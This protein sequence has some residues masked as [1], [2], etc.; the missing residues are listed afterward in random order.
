M[1]NFKLVKMPIALHEKSELCQYYLHCD[2]DLKILRRFEY[3][4][5]RFYQQKFIF[6]FVAISFFSIDILMSVEQKEDTETVTVTYWN[7]RGRCEPIRMLLAASGVKFTNV[8]FENP[9]QWN[10]LQKS[11]KLEYGQVPLVEMDGLNLV[12]SSAI[13]YYIARKYDL[14]PTGKSIED[15]KKAYTV[16]QVFEAT[17]DCRGSLAGFPFT[18]NVSQIFNEYEKKLK[19]RYLKKW[20]ELILQN[21]E[22]SGF[23]VG[24]TATMADVCI[25]EILDYLQAV[26]GE[27]QYLQIVKNLN[28]VQAL[29]EKILSLGWMKEYIKKRNS[30]K[31]SWEAYAKSVQRV[32][33]DSFFEIVYLIRSIRISYQIKKTFQISLIIFIL[34]DETELLEEQE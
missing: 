7:G 8:F 14:Y 18:L 12:Q 3:T 26:V 32:A 15:V 21:P 24:K 11:G 27:E 29:P 33:F 19:P 28:A 30:T 17:K 25:F 20:D 1:A 22:K 5:S 13:C 31:L 2:Y 16:D 23:I 10:K 34:N 9:E 6:A 4:N